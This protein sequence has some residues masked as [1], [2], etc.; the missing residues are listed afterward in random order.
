M[1]AES[2]YTGPGIWIRI[3]HRFGPRMTE[4]IWAT[5][6]TAW[7]GSLLL[8]DPVFDQPSFAFFRAFFDEDTFGWLMVCVGLLRLVG[9][10][11][12]GA[13][14]NV[15]PWIR[16][17]SACVGFMVFGGINYCFAYSGVIST[18]IAIY[19]MLALVEL[20]N[21]YR[22]AHDAGENYAVSGHQ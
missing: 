1:T 2:S 9:L 13:R 7:G 20:L 3:Q 12:N 22:A 15:T 14:K 16:V 5:I 21:A 10:I 17:F 8:P 11:I 6:M 18:W 19:P 4:W